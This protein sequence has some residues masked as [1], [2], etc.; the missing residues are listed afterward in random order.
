MCQKQYAPSIKSSGAVSR[1][2]EVDVSTI[3]ETRMGDSC[4]AG[5]LQNGLYV[6]RSVW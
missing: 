5:V 3:D 4:V 1:G 6:G 2:L